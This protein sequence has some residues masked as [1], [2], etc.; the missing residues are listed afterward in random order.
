VPDLNRPWAYEFNVGRNVTRGAMP[1]AGLLWWSRLP[2]AVLAVLSIA[3]GFFLIKKVGG[4]FPAYLWLLFACISPY[5]LL[6]TRRAM[7]ESPI[8]FFV[9]LAALFC[10]LALKA[11]SRPGRNNPW[12][13]GLYLGLA[14]FCVGLAGESKINGLSVL[15]GILAS[16]AGYI[17]WKQKDAAGPK[18]QRIVIYGAVASI[19]AVIAFFGSYPFL[20]PDLAARTEMVLRDRITEMQSQSIKHSADAIYTPSQRLTII[21]VRVFQDYA[22][23]NFPG[24]LFL[25]LALA[26]LG[27]WR[28]ILNIRD[29]LRGSRDGTAALVLLAIGATAAIPAFF[30]LLDWDRYYLF[31]IF[32]STAFIVIA[33]GWL[34]EH[35]FQLVKNRVVDRATG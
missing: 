28:T 20:W 24:A 6:Q 12:L 14:G 3:L 2:M 30:T 1:S 8:L 35:A 10:Y 25:N 31:P 34:G 16:L 11:L 26:C 15:L 23:I 18:A 9:M 22:V 7:A 19:V 17:I 33:L 4:R 32:F 5:L 21:P 13:I 27:I 29:W